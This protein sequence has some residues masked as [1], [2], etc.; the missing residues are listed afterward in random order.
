MRSRPGP[1]PYPFPFRAVAVPDPVALSVVSVFRSLEAWGVDAVPRGASALVAQAS[2]LHRSRTTRKTRPPKSG[3][4]TR[5]PQLP[6][7]AG[8]SRSGPNT[9][10]R[11][12]TP[13]GDRTKAGNDGIDPL[14]I[15]ICNIHSLYGASTIN[16]RSDEVAIRLM[17]AIRAWFGASPSPRERTS[18]VVV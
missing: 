1:D 3:R 10:W 6:H 8:R 12:G 18:P 15:H 16:S 7:G 17:E 11:A 13:D 2:R 5:A 14:Q 4:E 9:D